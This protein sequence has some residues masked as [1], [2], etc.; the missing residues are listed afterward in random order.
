VAKART[1]SP[2]DQPPQPDDSDV[3]LLAEKLFVRQWQPQQ[4]VMPEA[5]A[6]MCFDGAAAFCKV[7]SIYQSER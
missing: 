4:N 3:R 5:L 7:A 2:A 1:E 6:S